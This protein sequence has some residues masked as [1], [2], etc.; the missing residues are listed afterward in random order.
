[1]FHVTPVKET[2]V[3]GTLNDIANPTIEYRTPYEL[4][5]GSTYKILVSTE[6]SADDELLDQE[7][8]T[9]GR[10]PFTSTFTTHFDPHNQNCAGEVPCTSTPMPITWC[11]QQGTICPAGLACDLASRTCLPTQCP[12][13]CTPG[14]VC[15]PARKTCVVDCRLYDGSSGCPTGVCQADGLCASSGS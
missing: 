6:A 11:S 13:R 2:P 1:M 5:H 12:A 8:A 7:P 3:V 15:D 10:Q 4:Y 9:P 14:H